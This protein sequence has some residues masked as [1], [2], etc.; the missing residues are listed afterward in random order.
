[1]VEHQAEIVINRPSEEVFQGI[2]DVNRFE[3]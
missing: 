1:M 2:Y 3:Q